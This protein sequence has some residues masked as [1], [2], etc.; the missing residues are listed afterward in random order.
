M[1]YDTPVEDRCSED[2]EIVLT[3]TW[4]NLRL[5]ISPRRSWLR[6]IKALELT[7]NSPTANLSTTAHLGVS[8]SKE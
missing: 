1:M 3:V 6:S 8:W 7:R 4:A 5:G 2:A